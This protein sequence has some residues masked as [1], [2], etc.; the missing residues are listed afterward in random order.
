MQNDPF[1]EKMEN[2]WKKNIKYWIQST[3]FHEKNIQEKERIKRVAKNSFVEASA[4]D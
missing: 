3:T 2:E 4:V 1:M